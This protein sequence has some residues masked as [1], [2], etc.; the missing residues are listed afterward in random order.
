MA[1]EQERDD[2]RKAELKRSAEKAAAEAER[3]RLEMNGANFPVLGGGGWS[4]IETKTRTV[5]AR[6]P[7]FANMARDWKAADDTQKVLDESRRQAALRN[8]RDS[9]V[10]VFVY[11]K[12]QSAVGQEWDAFE[13]VEEEDPDRDWSNV[14]HRRKPKR[15]ITDAE[16]EEK[17]ARAGSEDEDDEHN[18]DLFEG[19]RR[20][21]N[22]T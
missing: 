5:E 4:T 19:R 15:E 14:T 18:A 20:D 3:K 1:R 10:P 8:E 16:I 2:R 6:T 22:C 21:Y 12:R 11:R 9:A 17:Y 13:E 7:V